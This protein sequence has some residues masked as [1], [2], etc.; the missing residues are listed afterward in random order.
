MIVER[1]RRVYNIFVVNVCFSPRF[2][3]PVLDA[4][5]IAKKMAVVCHLCGNPGHKAVACHATSGVRY[6]LAVCVY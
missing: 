2:D 4:Q 1:E 5:Q 6:V 3:I